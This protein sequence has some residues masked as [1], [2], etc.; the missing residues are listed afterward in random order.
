MSEDSSDSSDESYCGDY[1]PVEETWTP[2]EGTNVSIST[3]NTANAV[4]SMPEE[5]SILPLQLAWKKTQVVIDNGEMSEQKDL[6]SSLSPVK[7]Q[8]LVK[9]HKKRLEQAFEKSEMLKFLTVSCNQNEMIHVKFKIQSFPDAFS[10]IESKWKDEGDKLAMYSLPNNLVSK[11]LFDFFNEYIKDST[12]SFFQEHNQ[13]HLVGFPSR[14]TVITQAV[15]AVERIASNNSLSVAIQFDP[16]ILKLLKCDMSMDLLK[17]SLPNKTK[18]EFIVTKNHLW[19]FSN[20]K[21]IQTSL[22]AVVK[23][24]F[25][26]TAFT[27]TTSYENISLFTSSRDFTTVVRENESKLLIYEQFPECTFVT[28][29]KSIILKLWLAEEQHYRGSHFQK[30]SLQLQNEE[31]LDMSGVHETKE[32]TPL[33]SSTRKMQDSNEY[34]KLKD[35]SHDH[36]YEVENPRRMKWISKSGNPTRIKIKIQDAFRRIEREFKCTLSIDGIEIKRQQFAQWVHPMKDFHIVLLHG[37]AELLAADVICQSNKHLVCSQSADQ[38]VSMSTETNGLPHCMV[39]HFSVLTQSAKHTKDKSSSI[40][41]S[42]DNLLNAVDKEQLYSLVIP[43]NVISDNLELF[44]ENFCTSIQSYANRATSIKTIYVCNENMNVIIKLMDKF[45]R[46]L[47][48]LHIYDLSKMFEDPNRS[49]STSVSSL[50]IELVQG[51]LEKQK[52]D[53][54]VNSV[55]RDLDLTRGAVSIYML[56]EG[57]DEIMSDCR[58]QHPTGVD[59]GEIVQTKPGKLQCKAIYHFSVPHWTTNANFSLQILAKAVFDCL[60]LASYSK[61]KTISFPVLGTGTLQYPWKD[62]SCAMVDTIRKFG[63]MCHDSTL[64]VVQ[65]VLFPDNTK[66]IEMFED[67]LTAHATDKVELIAKENLGSLVPDNSRNSY[68]EC[69]GKRFRIF[70]DGSENHFKKAVKKALEMTVFERVSSLAIR[71]MD[72]IDSLTYMRQAKLI[73]DTTCEGDRCRYL[74]YIQLII[75]NRSAY[76]KLLV[77]HVGNK[78]VTKRFSFFGGELKPRFRQVCHHDVPQHSTLVISAVANTD[79]TLPT[80]I[81][82]EI[83][84]VLSEAVKEV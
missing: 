12:V 79:N 60:S 63:R 49:V 42:I 33:C 61:Y 3:V 23:E 27:N 14:K 8:F 84:R 51:N 83:R 43:S 75:L 37:S 58:R 29:T 48:F 24:N 77:K 71:L 67:C 62:V 73:R 11:L 30:I 15:A 50:K 5:D 66:S 54:L 18:A 35:K 4:T 57:G 72:E 22:T 38:A 1:S 26:S 76:D 16:F 65:I 17:S 39:A 21:I 6:S 78:E 74:Q 52:T 56:Q 53:V 70:S 44:A 80:T 32:F 9:Y 31:Y 34:E 40:V 46:G 68:T 81:E 7:M 47:A 82:G 28:A 64:E 69:H 2:P 25:V 41:R 36:T 13:I 55:G 19:V 59:Y 10:E 20:S 45:K